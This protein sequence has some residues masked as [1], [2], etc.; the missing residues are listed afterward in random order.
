M[1][2]AMEY[3]RMIFLIKYCVQTMAETDLEFKFII[4]L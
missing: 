1:W 2:Q 3:L 4:I